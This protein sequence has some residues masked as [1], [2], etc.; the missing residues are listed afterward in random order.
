MRRH[1]GAAAVVVRFDRDLERFDFLVANH[2]VAA[3]RAEGPSL[4]RALNGE[5]VVEFERRRTR[6]YRMLRFG[7]RLGRTTVSESA[8]IRACN[9]VNGGARH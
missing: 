4:R 1:E 6:T 8:A 2:I 3:A 5:S 7:A 9:L